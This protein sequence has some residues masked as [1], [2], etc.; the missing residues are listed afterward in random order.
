MQLKMGRQQSYHAI[1]QMRRTIYMELSQ[2]LAKLDP[3]SQ[4][5]LTQDELRAFNIYCSVMALRPEEEDP[6]SG[7]SFCKLVSPGTMNKAFDGA[8]PS[9]DDLEWPEYDPDYGTGI[10][11]MLKHHLILSDFF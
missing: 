3:P 9:D 1:L 10:F 2:L 6:N 5:S 11:F 4:A 8:F 7:P